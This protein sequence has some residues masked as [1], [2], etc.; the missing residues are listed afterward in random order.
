MEF[1]HSEIRLKSPIFEKSINATFDKRGGVQREHGVQEQPMTGGIREQWP[2]HVV[3][4]GLLQQG[5]P[6][7]GKVGKPG[8]AVRRGI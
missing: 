2:G 5:R 8:G 7:R 1:Q 6:Q 3:L 4:R